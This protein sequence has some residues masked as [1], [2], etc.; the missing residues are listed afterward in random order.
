[1][2]KLGPPRDSPLP[3]APEQSGAIKQVAYH[4]H[5]QPKTLDIPALQDSEHRYPID[6]VTALRLAGAGNLQIALAAERVSQAQARLQGANAQWLPSLIGGAGYTWHDGQIQ[7]TRGDVI[8]VRRNS[9]FVG[10]GP[11]LGTIGVAGEGTQP[12]MTVGL[13]LSD[14]LF[15]P[16]VERQ[17]V[18]G[19]NAALATAFN[20]TLLQV[21]LAYLDLL[22][23]QA[24]VAIAREAAANAEELD[25]LVDS[26]VRAGATLQADGL[27][28]RAELAERRRLLV[29]AEEGVRIASTELA[30]LLR[31]DP[32]VTLAPAEDQPL[33]VTLVDTDT[34]LPPL[35]EQALLERPELAEQQALVGATRARL[36]QEQWRPLIPSVQLGFGAGGFGGG[37]GLAV[38][39]FGDRADFDA[40]VVWEL[41][42]L[43]FGNYALSRERASVHQQAALSAAQAAEGIA[44]EVAR[45]YFQ[46]R[47]HHVQ[48]DAARAQV[49]AAAEALPLNF[50][51]IRGGELRAIEAQQA[52][53]TLAYA[54]TQYLAAVTGYNRA[55]HALL[56][57]IGQA[58]RQD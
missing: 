10:G 1:L 31:L 38:R 55:Q 29:Q 40:M 8:D 20:D 13:S 54:R 44:A 39:D 34:P 3:D 11:T 27:R 48:I 26:R 33:A 7:D 41:R 32:A 4:E 2:A 6:L 14:A 37:S 57:A 35:I 49:K 52:I 12:R 47:Q 36:R 16:L 5:G 17:S 50:K 46:A 23:A 9:L 15:A 24:Q 42:N 43:G 21:A 25:K 18:R 56:R 19:T 53:Q 22:Q 45:A 51:G 58:A 28:A 30:R